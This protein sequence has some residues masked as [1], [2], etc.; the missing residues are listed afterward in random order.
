MIL[1]DFIESINVY[2]LEG[3]VYFSL[4]VY[5]QARMDRA[6]GASI[7]LITVLFNLGSYCH[8]NRERVK[9][10][11]YLISLGDHK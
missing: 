8:A 2:D 11:K 1:K 10:Q 4:C 7:F 3:K 5:Q 9:G 6:L